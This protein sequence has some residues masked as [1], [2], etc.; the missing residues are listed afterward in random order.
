MNFIR[1]DWPVPAKVKS[2]ITTRTGG[3][4]LPPF[5]TLNLGIHVGDDPEHVLENRRRLLA[6]VPD[7]PKWLNQVH[8][9]KVVDLDHES[10]LEGDGS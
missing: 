10:V 5:D 6:R 7:K 3:V 2:L 9:R 1:P 4:S 8:G